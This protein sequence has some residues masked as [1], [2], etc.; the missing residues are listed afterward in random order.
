[1]E[2]IGIGSTGAES[3]SSYISRLA[4]AHCI[5]VGD[6][7]THLIAPK[8]DKKYINNMVFNGGNG[9][10]KSTSAING[11]GNIAEDFIDVIAFL[12]MR[13]DIGETTLVNC[14]GL[15]PFRGLLK[16]RRHWC[17]SCFQA[18]VESKQIVYERLS[19]TLQPYLKCFIHDRTL[20]SVCPFCKSCMYTLERKSVPGYCTKCFYWLGNFKESQNTT[21]YS[22]ETN[23]SMRTFFSEFINLSFESGCVSRSIS[24]YLEKNFEGSLTKAAEFFGYSKSTLWG[25]KA[26]AN[27]VPLKA[28]IDITSRLQLSLTG[29]IN[30][31]KSKITLKGHCS[32]RV[33]PL[34]RVKKDHKKIQEFLG[35]IIAEKKSYSLSEIANLMD[36]DRKLLT[37]TYP[38]ECQQIKTNYLSSLEAK[39]QSKN[40][41]MKKS[42][43]KAVYTLMKRGTYPSSGKVEEIVGKGKLHERKYQDYWNAKKSSMAIKKSI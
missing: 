35:L 4:D 32:D 16:S 14:R 42:I 24:F 12:T 2:P 21:I 30:M 25:W 43:D 17:P 15:V 8:L 41:I 36:C 28:L 11:H 3:L 37:Q 7:M 31:E 18:D 26:G 5:T 29:F 6:I 9:F 33:V 22:G 13:K 10:Y 39:K 38:N 20:E 34:G 40:K 23:E 1:M 19:W 27:L